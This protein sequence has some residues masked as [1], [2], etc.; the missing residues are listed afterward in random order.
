AGTQ[1]GHEG[2]LR[3][4]HTHPPLVRGAWLP[5]EQ[6]GRAAGEE[7][8]AVQLPAQLPHLHQNPL[9]P[10]PRP[11]PQTPGPILGSDP[12]ISA[13]PDIFKR[14]GPLIWRVVPDQKVWPFD[15]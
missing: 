13:R 8:V 4:H 2:T 7:E 12:R 10:L 1:A 5:A 15:L 6:R 14:S 11:R 9:N 3:A